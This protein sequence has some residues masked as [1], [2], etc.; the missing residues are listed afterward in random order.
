MHCIQKLTFA[1]A[2]LCATPSAYSQLFP[3]LEGQDLLNKLADE[4]TPLFTLS[5]S[6]A[7]DTMYASIYN[8][9]DSVACVY[10]GHTL[11]LPPGEDPSTALFMN[12][13]AD[14]INAEHSWPQSLGAGDGNARSDMHHLYPSRS[15]VN[16]ARENF[17]FAEIPDEETTSWYYR[18]EITNGIPTENIDLYSERING[19]F[20][21]RED[22][23]GNVARAMFYFNTIYHEEAQSV[24]PDFFEQQRMTLCDWHYLDPVDS[25]ELLRSLQIAEHQN[26]KANPFVMDCSVATR[27][28][29]EGWVS[30][31]CPILYTADK[32]IIDEKN[33]IK[34]YPNPA[35]DYIHI[36]APFEKGEVTVMNLMGRVLIK[37]DWRK[38]EGLDVSFL[39]RGAYFLSIIHEGFREV[40]RVELF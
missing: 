34:I 39:E 38:E 9:E 10:S 19:F 5:Y 24:N 15:G 4:F 13:S 29:C 32:K 40:L 1:I 7:R 12:N 37:K 20:E 11:Y 31:D 21:P 36:D 3:D 30:E 8:V 17:P 35:S 25:L 23:K 2:L 28:F 26:G 16:S 6:E 18:T 14:G 27:T 33:E 22:H